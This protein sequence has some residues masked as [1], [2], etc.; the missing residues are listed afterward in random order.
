MGKIWKKHPHKFLLNY[1]TTPHR[2]TGFNPAQLLFN[3]KVQSKLPQLTG[4]NQVTSQKT[5]RKDNEA[6][7]KMK[8]HV[9]MQFKVKLSR[10]DIGDLVLMRQRK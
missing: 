3:R 1:Q 10:I 8:V 4:N 5:Q 6:K 9:D 7:A 2:T